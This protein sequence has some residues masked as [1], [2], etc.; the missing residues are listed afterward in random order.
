MKKVKYEYFSKPAPHIYISEVVPPELYKTIHFPELEPAPHGRNGR[1]L[2]PGEPGYDQ[3]VAEPGWREVYNELVC[4]PFVKFVLSKF[5]NDMEALNCRI[6]ADNAYFEPFCEEREKVFSQ[7]GD[8]SERDPESLF[9][10]F[11]FQAADS[12]YQPYV[13]VDHSRRLVGGL[14][15]FCDASEEGLEG[16][17]FALYRDRL[18]SNDRFCHWP[19]VEEIFP[20][21][22]NTGVLLLNANTGFHGPRR[23]RKLRGLRKWVYYSISSHRVIWT[24]ETVRPIAHFADIMKAAF[25]SE[26]RDNVARY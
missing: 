10:R 21:K 11:D 18:F 20:I 2:Y 12:T 25:G 9:V 24:V 16:G 4:E 7:A 15:F 17:E 23:I 5:S 1:N 19:K 6:R 13:H 22:H 3:I 8:I 14:F 26:L